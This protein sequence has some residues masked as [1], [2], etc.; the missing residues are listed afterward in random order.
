MELFGVLHTQVYDFILIF[1]RLSAMIAFA[2]VF[3]AMNVPMVVKAS[4]A[5]T[6]AIIF[7]A[8]LPP[9]SPSPEINGWGLVLQL[10]G[11]A[12]IGAAIGFSATFIFEIIIFAGYIIDYMIGFGF[13]NVVDPQS[14]AS[15]SIFAFFYSFLTLILFLLVDGHHVLIEVMM[16][17]YELIPVFGMNLTEQSLITMTRMVSSVF[18]VGFQIAAPIFIIMFTIDFSLG[19]ISKTIPQLHVIVVGFPI[20]ITV[21]LIG[22]GI[23]L[24]PT[25]MFIMQMLEQYRENLLWIIKYLGGG[26]P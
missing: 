6:F 9:L 12:S 15:V 10:A 14:G 21:G 5:F 11:E 7:T 16:R 8:I 24:K 4:T 3:G 19:M 18:Y 2:P 17:S 22:L 1:A 23:I 13:I 25:V 20:K 26:S